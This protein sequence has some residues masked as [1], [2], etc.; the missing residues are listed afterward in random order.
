MISGQ[1][2][3][4]PY[5]PPY[6]SIHTLP[7]LK[8]TLHSRAWQSEAASG[9]SWGSATRANSCTAAR[10]RRTAWA[11]QSRKGFEAGNEFDVTLYAS[12][13]PHRVVHY[14]GQSFPAP[15]PTAI[16]TGS[17]MMANSRVCSASGGQSVVCWS[18]R[19]GAASIAD[20]AAST[21]LSMTGG[22]KGERS[23]A[24]MWKGERRVKWE[25]GG[26]GEHQERSRWRLSPSPAM[27]CR[28]TSSG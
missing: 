5:P 8:H 25:L 11:R 19:L 4:H 1:S 26:P 24:I 21:S 17:C 3:P 22:G 20:R 10:R 18:V 12:P 6:P 28:R 16:P 23:G 14:A 7:P 9:L 15:S 13:P 27:A 2:P